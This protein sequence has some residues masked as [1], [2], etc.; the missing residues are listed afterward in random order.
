MSN[1]NYYGGG[2][3]MGRRDNIYNSLKY[4]IDPTLRPEVRQLNIYIKKGVLDKNEFLKFIYDN[5]EY[6]LKSEAYVDRIIYTINRG[7]G[8]IRDMVNKAIKSADYSNYWDRSNLNGYANR[9]AGIKETLDDMNKEIHKIRG[10]AISNTINELWE[11]ARAYG[12]DID[13]SAK[14]LYEIIYLCLFMIESY[15][16]RIENALREISNIRQ[17]L[18]SIVSTQT[19]FDSVENWKRSMFYDKTVVWIDNFIY[20]Y[21]KF[22]EERKVAHI[23]FA[24]KL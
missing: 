15:D 22:D 7:R 5:L 18:Y 19:I 13:V 4:F 12:V 20:N 21:N 23:Q 3:N 9:M 8:L 14:N 6:S 24:R 17:E 1:H 10:R 11:N 2:Q 16:K